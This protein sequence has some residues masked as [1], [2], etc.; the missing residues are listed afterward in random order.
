MT[1]VFG[2]ALLSIVARSRCFS[3]IKVIRRESR[4]RDAPQKMADIPASGGYI[5]PARQH[6][7]AFGVELD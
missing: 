3:E 2:D 4:I 1:A 6:V 5:S 7:R